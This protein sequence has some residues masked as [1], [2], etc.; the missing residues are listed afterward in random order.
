MGLNPRGAKPV[1]AV[2]G[3]ERFLQMEAVDEILRALEAEMD[4]MGPARFDGTLATAADVFDEVRTLSLLGSRRVAIVEDAS[5]FI[6]EN[7]DALERYCATPVAEAS[8]ILVCTS[9]PKNTRLYKA[10]AKCGTLIK[11]DPVKPFAIGAWLMNRA[12]RRHGKRLAALASHRLYEHLGAP[13]GALDAEL[14]KLATFVGDR[15][16]I[17]VQDIEALTGHHREE[18]VFGV[19]DAVSS[20]DCAGA[21]RHWEQV[22]A[23]DRAASGRAIAGLAYGMGKLIEAK[24][25]WEA[26]VSVVTL[27]NRM[28]T[29]AD[30]L[31]RRLQGATLDQLERQRRDLLDADLAVKTGL[32][33]MGKAVEK[34]I[35][36]H[37]T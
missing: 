35:V 3:A 31:T 7:R 24:R 22:M 37:G 20:K 33:P 6:T 14:A 21:L 34:F 36:T 15:D 16:E 2:F 9:L 30:V 32:A 28:Y 4:E 10:I 13:L 8:L 29:D 11:C 19:I 27:A 1:Y 18:K 26:G 5:T 17:T 23:T 12:S 25:D